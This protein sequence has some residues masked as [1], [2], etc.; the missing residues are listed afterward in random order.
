MEEYKSFQAILTEV[1]QQANPPE[2]LAENSV[3]PK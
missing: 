2:K 3:N 1:N